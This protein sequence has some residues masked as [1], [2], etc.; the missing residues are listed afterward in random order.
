[1]AARTTH[2][3]TN[4]PTWRSWDDMKQRCRNPRHKF[5]NRYGGRG[6]TVCASWLKFETFLHE[7]GLKPKGETLGRI[8][9]NAGYSLSNCRWET[10]EQQANNRSSSRYIECWGIRKTVSQW[11]R[12][13]GLSRQVLRY[14][15]KVGCPPEYALQRPLDSAMKL[16]IE[17]KSA[18]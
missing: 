10:R 8:D 1:M 15:L 5:Y 2:G 18:C 3:M 16:F 7:M 17:R 13:V 14:R 11:A 9:N 6:I 12:Y 4:T